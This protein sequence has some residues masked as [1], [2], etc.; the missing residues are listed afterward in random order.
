[1]TTKR[2]PAVKPLPI[3]VAVD[4]MYWRG[5]VVS[6]F[7]EGYDE[8]FSDHCK[9]AIQ[10]WVDSIAVYEASLDSKPVVNAERKP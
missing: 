6:E 5:K 10:K 7:L 3:L 8:A 2:K 4:N 1:V 9:Q